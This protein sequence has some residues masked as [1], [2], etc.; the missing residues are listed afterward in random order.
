VTMTVFHSEEDVRTC[1]VLRYFTERAPESVQWNWWPLETRFL[2]RRAI[3]R[4]LAAKATHAEWIWFADADMCFGDN[5]IDSIARFN[6]EILS[7]PETCL[8]FPAQ[9]LMSRTHGL[10]DAAVEA[11]RGE[12]RILE[13]APEDFQPEHYEYAIG[14]AQICRGNVARQVGY[15]D[16]LRKY[17]MPQR[18]WKPTCEDRHFRLRLGTPGTPISIDKV[19]RIRHSVRGSDHVGVEL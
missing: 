9:V 3:G 11:A 16:N 5:C 2:L 1:L 6:S 12:P 18:Q 14:G 13:L 7:R 4:S 15:C 17:R 10:G 19:F 8:V